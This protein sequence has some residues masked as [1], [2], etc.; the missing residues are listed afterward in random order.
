MNN[1]FK[2]F[3]KILMMTVAILL[4]FVLISTSVVSGIFAKYVITRSAGATVSLKAFGLTLT[5]DGSHGTVTRNPVADASSTS[6][7]SVSVTNLQ[8]VP[9]QTLDDV[10][11]FTIGG[12][13]NVDK[14]KIKIKVTVTNVEKFEVETTDLQ[15]I[16][17]ETGL[18]IAKAN[19]I[20]LGFTMKS[21]ASSSSN[22][23]VV[24]LTPWQKPADN[25]ALA[26]SIRGGL[27]SEAKFTASKDP[28]DAT[29][30][31]TDTAEKVIYEKDKT[32]LS[33]KYYSFGFTCWGTGGTL[34]G[35]ESEPE[36][37]LIQTYLSTQNATANLIVTYT[38]SLEQVV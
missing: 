1:K 5:V 11:K 15:S 8:L 4:C 28:T 23:K 26:T 10:V 34:P 18:S 14:I 36:A 9:G 29:K 20:P 33:T 7:L 37:D 32:A 27:V 25:A 19:Y 31:T 21:G 38:V 22:T 12:A 3:N 17:P 13:P 30:T 6:T 24:L 16:T 35:S 2:R